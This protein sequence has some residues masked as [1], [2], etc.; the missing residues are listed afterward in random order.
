MVTRE[1]PSSLFFD[2][3]NP[4]TWPLAFTTTPYHLPT[5]SFDPQCWLSRHVGPFVALYN[6]IKI[7]LSVGT[8]EITDAEDLFRTSFFTLFA[9]SSL[10][11]RFFPAGLYACW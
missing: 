11:F 7:S 4:V 5:N 3:D 6:S 10:H 9:D 8:E 2:S 1:I